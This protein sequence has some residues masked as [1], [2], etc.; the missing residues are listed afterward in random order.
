[1]I[2]FL[3][4]YINYIIFNIIIIQDPTYDP[5]SAM[6]VNMNSYLDSKIFIGYGSAYEFYNFLMDSH[7][8]PSGSDS[9]LIH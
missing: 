7:L 6:I 3:W 1:M 2:I 9:N 4:S 5:K 8:N